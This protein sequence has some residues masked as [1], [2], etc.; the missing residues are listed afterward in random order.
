VFRAQVSC[1]ELNASVAAELYSEALVLADS[2]PGEF[3][4]FRA[5]SL[6]PLSGEAALALS[7]E[8]VRVALLLVRAKT[9]LRNHRSWLASGAS[10][11]NLRGLGRLPA[12]QARDTANLPP[13][14]D[15]LMEIVSATKLLY[16]RLLRLDRLWHEPS[17]DDP[18]RRL[19]TSL[20]ESAA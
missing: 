4:A 9:W 11:A 17:R 8:Q 2:L 6:Y 1:H 15:E 3:A 12:F 14:P 13:L 5:S 19:V 18:V 7:W 20:R 16:L 10:R